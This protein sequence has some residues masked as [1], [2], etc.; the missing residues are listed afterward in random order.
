M[1]FS[2]HKMYGPKGVGALYVR[3]GATPPVR[4]ECQI[5]GGGHEHG[6]RSGTLNVPGIVGFAAAPGA[7]P[8]RNAGET[9]RLAGLRNRLFA[10]LD[11]GPRP[12]DAQRP[13]SR[14]GRPAAAG[15]S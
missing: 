2:A 3:H 14:T 15:Q 6:L 10:G 9:A 5:A 8:G 11:R 13:G 12:G 4:L 1:S 7:V